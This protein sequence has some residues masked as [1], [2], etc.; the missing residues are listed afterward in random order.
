MQQ[1]S[2]QNTEKYPK[3]AITATK[4]YSKNKIKE[5][6]KPVAQL[7]K[8]DWDNALHFFQTGIA[9]YNARAVDVSIRLYEKAL[10]LPETKL[11]KHS[12][13]YLA[14]GLSYAAQ[15]NY[16]EAIRH[17]DIGFELAPDN[18]L[19]LNNRSLSHKYLNNTPQALQDL[20]LAFSIMPDNDNI[21]LNLANMLEAT[22]SSD[23]AL[24][25]LEEKLPLHQEKPEFLVAVG[26]L[27]KLINPVEAL[28]F[29]RKAAHLEPKNSRYLNLYADIFNINRS[30]KTFD[31]LEHDLL[32]LLS[33]D[34]VD[35][36]KL[37]WVIPQHL[38]ADPLFKEVQPLLAQA[39]NENADINIDFGKTAQILTNNVL[40]AALRRI[41]LSDPELEKL[42]ELFR[43][44][45]LI[46]VASDI[47]LNPALSNLLLK[48]LTP[49]AEYCFVSE[50]VFSES[51]YESQIIEKLLAELEDTGLN[52]SVESVLKFAITCCY[53][54]PHQ[55]AALISAAKKL[56]LKNSDDFKGMI[57]RT[58]SEP[59]VERDIQKNVP[60][61]TAISDEISLSVQ[62]QYEENP[63]PRWIHFPF[64]G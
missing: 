58:L 23:E 25:I 4:L 26:K 17:Y 28:L 45:T 15:G 46:A 10:K 59:L 1:I 50:Y 62:E 21:L 54:Q 20:R 13:I 63:Y 64:Q 36:K 39:I 55:T 3:L 61:L 60:K 53:R 24:Q 19:I 31:G 56:K 52:S 44:Q 22:G 12:D 32:L 37:S 14:L 7:L 2:R 6:E 38:K 8:S 16:H 27:K 40:L 30:L 29:F 49:I 9:A 51:V 18:A 11:T 43:R 57:K 47:E 42:L 34:A 33:N 48:I 5:A 35:W 41:R